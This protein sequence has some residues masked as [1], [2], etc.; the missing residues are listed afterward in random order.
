MEHWELN[1][2]MIPM[3]FKDVWSMDKGW[4]WNYDLA[5]K[6]SGIYW[7]YYGDNDELS[8][9]KSMAVFQQ[10]YHPQMAD[11]PFWSWKSPTL[12]VETSENQ[13]FL[14]RKLLFQPLAG[15]SSKVINGLVENLKPGHM[16]LAI[17]FVSLPVNVTIVQFC[18][19]MV[20]AGHCGNHLEVSWNGGTTQLSS[21]FIR[22]S[23]INYNTLFK[24][25][26]IYTYVYIYI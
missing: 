12:W 9:S 23:S 11:V 20:L 2:T 26:Y 7:K 13:Q 16:V 22:F 5:I 17:K 15:S 18:D 4:K 6:T 1:W 25:I 24:Y 14:E 8:W 21:I 3:M 10:V 19:I